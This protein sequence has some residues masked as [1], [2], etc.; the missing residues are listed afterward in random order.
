MSAMYDS[1]EEGAPLATIVAQA[2]FLAGVPTEDLV[3]L[4]QIGVRERDV[5]EGEILFYAND[6]VKHIYALFEGK[7]HE[8]FKS[9]AGPNGK[10]T[11]ASTWSISNIA[12]KRKLMTLSHCSALA[13]AINPIS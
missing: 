5:G 12:W 1:W 3:H 6:P 13:A 8:D 11:F 10:P 2:P 7:I 4:C 9:S